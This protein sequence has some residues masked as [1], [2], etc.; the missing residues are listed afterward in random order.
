MNCYEKH[1]IYRGKKEGNQIY[2]KN[3]NIDRIDKCQ[4]LQMVST[5]LHSTEYD[6][7]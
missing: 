1:H 5:F 7:T 2:D 3:Q 6:I 4:T